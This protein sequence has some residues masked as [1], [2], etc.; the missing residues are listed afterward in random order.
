MKIPPGATSYCPPARPLGP[1]EYRGRS[2]R[3]TFRVHGTGDWLLI[4]TRAGSGLYR[5]SE[6]GEYRSRAGTVTLYRP[7]A[8]QDYQFSPE[9]SRW[10]LLW[11]HFLARTDWLSWLNW[12]EIAPGLMTL[13][14]Q[15]PALRRRIVLRLK[16]VIRLNSSS[17][18]RGQIL[19]LNALEEVLLW[20]DSINPRQSSSQLDPRIARAGDFL[21]T[22]L[23]E[24]FSEERLARAAGL[25]PSR[26]R[27]LFREQ[28]GDSPRHFQEQQRLQRAK[29][30]LAM[31]R[32]TI[33][34][35]A[36]ELGFTNPFYFTLRFKKHTG[37]SP[38][39]FRLR[40][41]RR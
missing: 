3:H 6:G 28:V 1:G 16:D 31:S 21:T 27:H 39:A 41:T 8:F 7:G 18:A 26:L 24:P 19:G 13:N 22:H 23:S 14:L 30:L 33:G 32:Q 11:A 29:D 37:E 20:C 34:E 5:F 38:R 12:P 15:E 36:L 2:I 10:D 25:S 17:Q 4:Y 40:T 35:I 9:T